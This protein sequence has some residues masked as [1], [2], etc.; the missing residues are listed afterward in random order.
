M[1]LVRRGDGFAGAAAAGSSG[2][3]SSDLL[4]IDAIVAESFAQGRRQAVLRS[5]TR[6]RRVRKVRQETGAKLRLLRL[7]SG[8]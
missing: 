3:V 7:A 1:L 4:T 2:A 8:M 6:S 5:T